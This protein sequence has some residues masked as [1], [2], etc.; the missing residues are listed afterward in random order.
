MAIFVED[1][2]T[3]LVKKTVSTFAGR[4][5]GVQVISPCPT[6]TVS[7]RGVLEVS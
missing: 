2:S 4:I 3:F 7:M 5:K 6:K 1:Y